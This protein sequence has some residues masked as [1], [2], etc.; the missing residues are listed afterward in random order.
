MKH[1]FTVIMTVWFIIVNA[2][3][4]FP[5]LDRIEPAILGIPF[6][7]WWIWGWNLAISIYLIYCAFRKW[8]TYDF[9]VEEAREDAFS[10][11]LEVK[12]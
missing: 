2:P 6:N 5:A 7:L 4:L 8:K 11:G 12:E 10:R 1:S 9:D 3:Q